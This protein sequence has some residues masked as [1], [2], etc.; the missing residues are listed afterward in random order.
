MRKGRALL[1]TLSM[2]IAALIGAGL[3]GTAVAAETATPASGAA[4]AEFERNFA[5]AGNLP[6]RSELTCHSV[7]AVEIC[8]QAYGDRWWV[9]DQL[10]DGASAVV[11]WENF[12]NGSL[13]RHGMC[14]NSLG[15]GKWGQCNKNYYENSVLNGFPCTWDRSSNENLLCN[16]RGWNFQ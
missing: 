4:V 5:V 3:P 9:Q 14:V 2:A 16:S 1:L 10:G 6:S 7:P 8:Y 11:K 13:Y 15:K 12:R